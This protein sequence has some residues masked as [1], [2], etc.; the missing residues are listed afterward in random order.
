VNPDVV[1]LNGYVHAALPWKAPVLVAAHSCVLSWWKAVKAEPPP[2]RLDHYAAAVRR[3]LNACDQVV[4]PSRAMATSVVEHYGVAAPLVISNG[5]SARRT[6]DVKEPFILCAA[7]LWDEAKNA[8]NLTAAADGLAWP[9][10]LAGDAGNHGHV[11]KN[12][13]MAGRC[14]RSAMDSWFRRAA[15][16]AHPALYEPFGLAP[17]EAAHAGCALVLADIPSLRE[18]W[19]DAAVF[20]PPGDPAAWRCALQGLISDPAA[21]EALAAKAASRAKRYTPQRMA[22]S[23][24]EVYRNLLAVSSRTQL[25]VAL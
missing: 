24:L 16:Y 21:R 10:V 1:H 8:A 14:S 15:V 6:S 4:A 2:A 9:L 17:L 7:R 23:Y 12:V 13:R 3:G 18:I 25:P 20:V 22:G 11:F 19:G 5:R